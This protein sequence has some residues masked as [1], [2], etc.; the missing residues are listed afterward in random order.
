M[1]DNVGA[2][3]HKI[4]TTFTLKMWENIENLKKSSELLMN[5]MEKHWFVWCLFDSSWYAITDNISLKWYNIKF[6]EVTFILL[7][8]CSICLNYTEACDQY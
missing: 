8:H 2:T 7:L 4:V 3:Q 5:T 1:S 6:L